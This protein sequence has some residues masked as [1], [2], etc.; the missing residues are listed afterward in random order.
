VLIALAGCDTDPKAVSRKYVE[1]GN[2]YF[3]QSKYK[4][5]FILYRR[6][7]NKDLRSPEAWY[8][9]G[10]VN[11]KLKAL[12]EARRDFSRAME[13]DPANR[14]A[15]IQLG[16]LNLA[17]YLLNPPGGRA[18]LADLQE[19]TQRLLKQDP[20]SFDA[21]RFSG[22]IALAK[23]DTAAAIKAFE[24][25]N[26]ARPDQPDL[27][28]TLLQT[29]FSD[30]QDEAGEKLAGSLIERHKAFPQLYEAL[31]VHYLRGNRPDLAEQVLEKQ[32]SD[33]PGQGMV[34]VQLASHYFLMHRTAD[35]QAT[36]AR[37]TA[38]PKQFPAGRLEAGDFYARI[39]D[40][41]AALGNFRA[42]EQQNPKSAR[43]YRK[44]IAAVLATEG[45]RDQAQTMVTELLREDSK[46]PEARALRA[47]LELASGE[48]RQVKA[49][50]SE[51]KELTNA[52]PSNATLHFNLGSAYRAAT[53]QQNL[54]LAREQFE[55]A[56]RID[57]HHAPA[58]LAW[59]ELSLGRGEAGRALAAAD[60]VSRDDP[61]NPTARLIRASA[62]V[63]MS[64]PQKARAELSDLLKMYPDSSDAREQLAELDLKERRCAQA[65]NGFHALIQANDPRGMA[66]LIQSKLAQREWQQAIQLAND[67]LQRSPDRLDYRET[68]ARIYAASG[69]FAA[70]ASQFEALIAKNPKSAPLYVQ[71]GEAKARRGDAA[72]A[73]A[74]FQTAR[75][76]APTD[77]APA[78]DL[79]LLY[80]QAGRS[81][82]ARPEYE[83]V[84]QLQPDNTAALNNLAYLD[85]QA[86]VDLDQALAH[87]QRAQQSAP[88][89]PNIEDTLALVYIRKNL[90]Q[91][92]IRMLRGL[93]SRNPDNPAFHLHL[94]LALYQKGDRP[95]ARR[96]LEAA[97]HNNPTSQEQARIKEL[98]AKI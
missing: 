23:D 5:A 94:A 11:A 50:I 25:A 97:S 16:D 56:L 17:F 36:I 3:A 62:L 33:N 9:L 89:D 95:T 13:L 1:R 47:T 92:G 83:T 90:T 58:K 30:Q 57:P 66:G 91:E 84:I 67:Q 76:L 26:Q 8:R 53:D 80:D 65:E 51:L 45:A 75:R 27:V 34:L 14:D 49:A 2:Q 29:L 88:D 52:M 82:D 44:R 20:R 61:A 81:A 43:V 19:I 6:A 12:P 46:D 35:V 39:H 77:P 74:A 68:L 41:P 85:A 64:E 93:V 55:I 21:L 15:V 96:E 10:L 24:A 60:E 7:L 79:A 70:A 22:N 54:E 78:L 71:L 42:G 63:K 40:Y 18:F 72:G 59:A 73:L 4:E 86:G 38:D 37:L 87:A 69:N 31:Y 48:A 32:I 98:L 28:L